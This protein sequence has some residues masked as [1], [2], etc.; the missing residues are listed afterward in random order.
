MDTQLELIQTLIRI[1]RDAMRTLAKVAETTSADYVHI[2]NVIHLLGEQFHI[3]LQQKEE[4]ETKAAEVITEAAEV[5][6]EAAEVTNE[7]AKVTTEV[8]EM[9]Q[10]T[11]VRPCMAQEPQVTDTVNKRGRGA[12]KT[13]Y[14]KDDSLKPAFLAQL[15]RI[16]QQYYH[17]GKTFTLPDGIKANA[18]DFLACL[19]DIGIKDGITSPEAP[20]FDMSC[21]LKE[22]AEA[23]ENAQDFNTAYNTLQ[24]AVRKWKSLTGNESRYYCTNVRFH[25]LNPQDVPSEYQAAYNRWHNLYTQVEQIYNAT[26]A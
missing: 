16:F 2:D 13:Y 22:A 26:K 23:C 15:K 3:L 9:V 11:A 17:V 1:N 14:L 8:A 7:A 5:I 12:V 25:T 4:L 20:V 6:T 10:R 18:P 19:Y 21:M 24:K